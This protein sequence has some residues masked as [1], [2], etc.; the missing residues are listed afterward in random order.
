MGAQCDARMEEKAAASRRT[1]KLFFEEGVDAGLGDGFVDFGFGAAGGDAAESLTVHFD[2]EA[3]LVGK[4][5]GEGESFHAAFFHSIGGV[6]RRGSVK[7]GVAGFLLRPHDGVEG[8]AI[9]LLKEEEIAAFVHDADGDFDVLF[10]CFGFSA[11]DHG[12]DG[13]E[14]DVFF[15]WEIGSDSGDGESE[16]NKK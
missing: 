2:G 11:G 8:G 14:V 6:F 10:F 9:G 13:R 16:R 4:E 3:A 12:L 1:P 7:G 5:I 15:G